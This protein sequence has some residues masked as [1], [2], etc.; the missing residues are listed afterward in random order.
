MFPPRSRPASLACQVPQRAAD[1]LGELRVPF[2]AGVDE[3]LE[4]RCMSLTAV[5]AAAPALASSPP[6]TLD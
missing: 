1:R 6:A 3:I 4:P 2:S 5:P